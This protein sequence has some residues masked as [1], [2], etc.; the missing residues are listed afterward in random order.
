MTDPTVRKFNVTWKYDTNTLEEA[1]LGNIGEGAL[2]VDLGNVQEDA[3]VKAGDLL[4][5]IWQ[6]VEKRTKYPKQFPKNNSV[7][8]LVRGGKMEITLVRLEKGHGGNE[9]V[10]VS[11][12]DLSC[13]PWDTELLEVCW[14][15]NPRNDWPSILVDPETTINFVTKDT[16]SEWPM[17]LM[18]V[19]AVIIVVIVGVM[20][21]MIL[22]SARTIQRQARMYEEP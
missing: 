15:M 13:R 8:D 18:I 16:S 19:I 9:R 6:T 4:D 7:Y 11:S 5:K 1:W 3:T 17:W 10:T 21:G 14:K 12:A 22:R 20:V 2:E